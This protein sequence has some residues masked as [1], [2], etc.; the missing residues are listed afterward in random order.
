MMK[1]LETPHYLLGKCAQVMEYLPVVSFSK[2]LPSLRQMEILFPTG[3]PCLMEIPKI[4]TLLV[5]IL[6]WTVW[7]RIESELE[8]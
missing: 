6:F 4:C 7:N 8:W 2:D 1:V 5:T 3:A